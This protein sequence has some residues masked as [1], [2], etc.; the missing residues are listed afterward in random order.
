[1]RTVAFSLDGRLLA[2]GGGD[3]IVHL[4]DTA[5]WREK[6]AL[7]GHKGNV[8]ALAFLSNERLASTSADT[9]VLVWDVSAQQ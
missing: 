3:G 1:M 9:T 8:T 7:R 2:F 4:W 5:T 6:R